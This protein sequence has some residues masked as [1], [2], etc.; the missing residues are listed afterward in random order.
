MVDR[1]GGGLLRGWRGMTGML[2][3]V[4]TL[5]EVRAVLRAGVAVIDL[6]DPGQGV[7]GGLPLGTV[8]D[9]VESVGGACL[10]S[11]TIGDRPVN[12]AG[13]EGAIMAMHQTGVD[14]VKVGVFD[15][16]VQTMCRQVLARCADN[17][18][19]VVLVFFAE[20]LDALP[21]FQGLAELGVSGV[22]LDTADKDSGSLT[23]R[24]G[25]PLLARFVRLARQARLLC[26]LA[27]SLRCGDI[28]P[29]LR[30]RPDYLGFRGALCRGQARSAALDEG[31]LL[32]VRRMFLDYNGV[33]I[34]VERE[35][36][37]VA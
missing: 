27:G 10:V 30:L 36:G 23:D 8:G 32:R 26:G 34:T 5:H 25:L 3:S 24:L 12:D 9:A 11:A 17:G 31:A 18:V 35:Y 14:Y 1:A 16:P 19:S 21:D 6:K 15:P 22:M 28:P 13:L 29:L 20:G 7:L 37:S 2:A 33:P 4:H